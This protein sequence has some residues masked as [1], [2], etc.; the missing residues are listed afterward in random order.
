MPTDYST[1]GNTNLESLDEAHRF[2]EWM[3]EQIKPHLIGSILEI[4]SGTGTYSKKIVRD[5]PHN[6]LYLSELDQQ[7]VEHLRSTF[8]GP[9]RHI[10]SLDIEVGIGEVSPASIDAVF[11]LNVFEHIRDD[12]QAL[13]NVYRLL[14]PGG[15]FVMLVPAHPSLYNRIDASIDHFRRYTKSMARDKATAAGFSIERLYFFNFFS[16]AGW[17]VNGNILKKETLDARL[18]R[19]FDRLVPAFRFIERYILRGSIG[20]SLI[21]VLRKPME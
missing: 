2:T 15:C 19:V 6:T 20:I 1:T 12:D 11:A 10:L 18:L 4:G 7:Y 5:F 13:R 9:S 3:Y 16:I 14:K 21:A 8:G 17:W